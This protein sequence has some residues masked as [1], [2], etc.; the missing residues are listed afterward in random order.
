MASAT[1]KSSTPPPAAAPN[2]A[3]V[4]QWSSRYRGVRLD[5]DDFLPALSHLYPSSTPRERNISLVWEMEKK[6]A[7]C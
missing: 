3:F 6:S 5:D 4:S 2:K 1:L 7:G